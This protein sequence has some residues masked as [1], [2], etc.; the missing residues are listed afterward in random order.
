MSTNALEIAQK[1]ISFKSF[2]PTH[3]AAKPE[4]TEECRKAL[5]YLK[6][7]SKGHLARILSFEGGDD[8]YPH[9]IDNLWLRYR[10]NYGAV[11]PRRLLYIGHIDV[12][13]VK[14]SDWTVPA[15]EG[16][17]K[18]GRLY[19]RGATDM[20]GPLATF[21]A[22][23]NTL[24][25]SRSRQNYFEVDMII[26]SDEEYAA[27]NGVKRV[28]EFIKNEHGLYYDAVLV[29]EAS[30]PNRLGKVIATG[31]RG[32]LNGKVIVRGKKGHRAYPSSYANPVPVLA[33]AILALENRQFEDSPGWLAH[34]DLEVRNL[35]TDSDSTSIIPSFAEADWNIR[36][37]GNYTAVELKQIVEETVSHL[38]DDQFEVIV[39]CSNYPKAPYLSKP[40]HGNPELLNT[41]Q[42]FLT[43]TYG[44]PA[45]ETNE[46][47]MSDGCHVEPVLGP[48][49][50]IEIGPDTT[51]MHQN[52]ESIAVADLDALQRMF[53][54]VIPRYC[55]RG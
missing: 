28:L 14:E 53:E 36:Y 1:L 20:K 33:E 4:D 43:E 48:I 19:G 7:I 17:V 10:L 35:K 22:A 44:E 46:G 32:S 8:L 25:E 6:S 37:T 15:F 23:M 55:Q 39:E 49:E 52:D 9:R 47:G 41:F 34:T 21:I 18:E 16:V 26:T 45:Q 12:V 13:P 11:I 24:M 5:E 27:V 31:R 42:A 51:P 30:S 2:T 50:I 40:K 54:I 38:A 29:G 3:P